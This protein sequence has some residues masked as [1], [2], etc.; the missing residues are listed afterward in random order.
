LG[1]LFTDLLKSLRG[2]TQ[3]AGRRVDLVTSPLF[4]TSALVST[5]LLSFKD[6][7]K[8]VRCSSPLPTAIQLTRAHA[9]VMCP[10][11]DAD[12]AVA[13]CVDHQ[14][15][16]FG[17]MPTMLA[18]FLACDTFHKRKVRRRHGFPLRAHARS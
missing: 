4:H 17:C 14:V 2:A 15:T 16:F 10:K 6:G 11:W 1:K 18:D 9:Q 3:T 7:H 8:L 5:F 12:M 13:L